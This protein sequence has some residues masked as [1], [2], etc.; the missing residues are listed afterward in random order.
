VM[1]DARLKN[2]VK[3]IL[4][5]CSLDNLIV[6][7]EVQ[8]N[9]TGDTGEGGKLQIDKEIDV[10][11][12]FSFSGKK[13]LL[14]FE[15][16][17]S[18]ETTGVKRHY[19]EYDNDVRAIESNSDA[20]KVIG[21]AD[22]MLQGRH[23]RDV[24]LTRVC[25]VYGPSFSDR[26]YRTCLKEAAPHSFHVW[27]HVVLAYYEAISTVLGRWTRYELFK[28]FALNL[29]ATTTFSISALKVKQK[30]KTMY[31][32]TIHPGLLLKIAYVVRRA[33]ERTLAYQRMLSKDRI[34]IIGEFISSTDPQSFIPNAVIVVID[35]E[36]KLRRVAHY[37]AKKH[38][39]TL[40]LAY[41][42]AWMIDG[43]HRAF[44][45]LGTAYEDWTE[46]RHEAFDLP[47]VVFLELPEVLQTQTFININYFQK[48]IKANLLCDLA[49]S[50]GNLKYKLTWPSLV[51]KALND[52]E[53]CPIKGMVKITELHHGRPI[54]LSSL[55]QYGLLET[56]LGFRAKPDR[57]SGPLF[58]YAPFDPGAQVDSTG[59]RTA[60]LKQLQ[61]LKRFLKAVHLN[62]QT[63]DERT[64][65][66]LNASD[67]SLV[68]PTGINAL[69][70][71]LARILVKHPGAALDLQRF[72][73]PLRTIS[74]KSDTVAKM[75]GGWKG[76]RGLAN[77][78]IRRLNRG[79]TRKSSML[80][81]YGEKEKM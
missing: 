17:D 30:G 56:L 5:N 6:D 21:S 8:I 69:F 47:V 14:M 74:F 53:G 7:R 79:K 28:E 59:N 26:S 49:T 44:G 12:R 23:F 15:C 40:P 67:Y 31:L 29:E 75:G 71:V 11:A 60:L 4:E 24:D 43:Q 1:K 61:L 76:F 10:I 18:K 2:A 80:L 13:I 19:R 70:M 68:R 66:W 55:V 54:S 25:F 58:A 64:D 65:P 48:R 37:D 51:G 63:G 20:I 46:E 41:C 16:E 73:R 77:A 3:R 22:G 35:A 39:L 81:A 72:L 32:G 45:F 62:T 34:A 36:P 9:F 33:S 78:I 52:L 57:Y 38:E 50:T 42:S 27:N